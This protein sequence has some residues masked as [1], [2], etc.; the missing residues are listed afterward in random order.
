[1]EQYSFDAITGMFNQLNPFAVVPLENDCPRHFVFNNSGTIMYVA[2]EVSN[3][4]TTYQVN[5]SNGQIAEIQK[6]KTIPDNFTVYT[7]C[8]DIHISPDNR[9]VYISNRGHESIAAFRVDPNDGKLTV[10]NQY[11]TVGTPREFDIDPSGNYLYV[12]G[13]TSNDLMWFRINTD[14]T[15][16][17][18]KTIAVG[19]T[20]SWVATVQ[21]QK[22][23]S[24]T[25]L[26]N[27]FEHQFVVYPNPFHDHFSVT[28][29][30]G[31]KSNVAMKF[32]DVNGHQVSI[33]PDNEILC[34]ND[35]FE[36]TIVG[37]LPSGV[38]YC[39]LN[40]DKVKEVLKLIRG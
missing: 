13:E 8:A 7:K 15:L 1:M 14:G 6:L 34:Y 10:I 30:F 38:Y 21:Y 23:V 26:E 3:C 9:F 29:K 4:L 32:F 33:L 36:Y 22:P 2:N 39:E 24:T 18:L 19:K 16:D 20:P 40:D 5:T 37:S 31:E 11:H 25:N 35:V 17:S 27:V 28:S 12:A